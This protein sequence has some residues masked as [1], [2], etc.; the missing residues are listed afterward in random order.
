MTPWPQLTLTH[1]EWHRQGEKG[2]GR[3][4][5][6]GHAGS[7]CV[8]HPSD[9]KV[10]DSRPEEAAD[11]GC[12]VISLSVLMSLKW[13][14]FYLSETVQ[15][16]P[17]S[18]DSLVGSYLDASRKGIDKTRI[19]L[20]GFLRTHAESSMW[21]GGGRTGTKRPGSH[22][23]MHSG[24]A[25]LSDAAEHSSGDIT[26][27]PSD[28]KSTLL[29]FLSLSFRSQNGCREQMSESPRTGNNSTY[30]N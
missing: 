21:G 29:T 8:T 14:I 22:W 5:A 11:T 30:S 12:V 10:N 26:R 19:Y 18:S 20:D 13:T 9:M 25:A 23:R 27:F 4:L 3:D 7:W 1:A 28:S 17:L 16:K 2:R 24:A 6:G 15:I